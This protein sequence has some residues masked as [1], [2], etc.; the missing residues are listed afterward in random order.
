M[1]G[2]VVAAAKL[3]DLGQTKAEKAILRSIAF[4]H[5]K[6]KAQRDGHVW[7]VQSAEEFQAHGVDYSCDRIWRSIR[8]LKGRGVLVVERHFHPFKACAGPVL[9]IRPRAL[10]VVQNDQYVVGA[11]PGTEWAG[12]PVGSGQDAHFHIDSKTTGG[13]SGNLTTAADE[14]SG[15]EVFLGFQE[16]ET[17][18]TEAGAGAKMIAS[19]KAS[20]SIAEALAIGGT[21]GASAFKAKPFGPRVLFDTFC[22]AYRSEYKITPGSWN[23]QRGGMMNTV[24]K[25]LNDEGASSDEIISFMHWIVHEWGS[26]TAWAKTHLSLNVKGER[27]NFG[28]VTKYALE[29][30]GYWREK[31]DAGSGGLG[32]TG[33]SVTEDHE[34]QASV[35]HAPNEADA[36]LSGDFG[37]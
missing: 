3:E 18:P 31:A 24:I 4:W 15:E 5:P 34:S 20:A 37:A 21:K 13:G 23:M 29:A 1:A 22:D 14:G 27:P 9:W 7:L 11:T 10:P 36:F 26:F 33:S 6:A 30:Y 16:N 12:E 8:A 17:M 28:D 25:R 2:V 35:T 32:S 19:K